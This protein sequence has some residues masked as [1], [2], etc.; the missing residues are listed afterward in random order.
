MKLKQ[1]ISGS[2]FVLFAH[3]NGHN[4]PQAMIELVNYLNSAMHNY[5][6][7]N[8][9]EKVVNLR[10]QNQKQRNRTKHKHVL[11]QNRDIIDRF[12]GIN[13]DITNQNLN[14]DGPNDIEFQGFPF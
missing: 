13:N 14:V 5:R 8:S 10:K 12:L 1:V 4:Q 11:E 3:A 6:L 7:D 9:N 2:K